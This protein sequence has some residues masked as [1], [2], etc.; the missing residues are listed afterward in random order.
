MDKPET[1]VMDHEFRIRL[2]TRTTDDGDGSIHER[3]RDTHEHLHERI[4][5]AVDELPGVEDRSVEDHT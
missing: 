4:R 5:K 3:L 2:R 1:R